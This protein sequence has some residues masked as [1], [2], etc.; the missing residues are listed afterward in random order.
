MRHH[1]LPRNAGQARARDGR[2]HHRAVRGD[3]DPGA[4]VFTR[5][6][7]RGGD[8]RQHGRAQPVRR[9]DRRHGLR[10][11]LHP[12]FRHRP[13]AARRELTRRRSLWRVSAPPTARPSCSGPPTIAN[14][15]EWQG[16]SSRAPTWPTTRDSRTTPAAAR[17]ATSSTRPSEPGVGSTI[18]PHMQKTADAAG[19][20]NSRY[21][22]PSEVVVHPQLTRT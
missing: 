16:R 9:H 19:I 17:T 10:A 2:L 6:G 1:R 4:A 12:A 7:R 11:D 5:G 18:S 13:A 14:G 8:A 20:G 22:L 15:N 21:N 3:L